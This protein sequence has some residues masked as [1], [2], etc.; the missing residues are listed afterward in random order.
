[1]QAH[2]ARLVVGQFCPGMLMFACSESI[3]QKLHP[4]SG[5]IEYAAIA[6]SEVTFT[7]SSA[8]PTEGE[9]M[10][11]LPECILGYW[12]HSHEEDTQDVSIYRRVS[13][14]F[15]PSRGRVAFEFRENGE[16]VY[17]AIGRADGS[18]LSSGRWSFEA[19]NRIKVDI[20]N[21]NLF[22][23][24]LRIS[25]CDENVLNIRK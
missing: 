21:Q 11:N 1:M 14:N 13:H 25:Y 22:P 10:E 6:Q 7:S 24:V 8:T 17:Q 9:R 19:E 4:P 5:D 12:I 2:L 16:L 23:P 15:P 20:D 3:P 18:E